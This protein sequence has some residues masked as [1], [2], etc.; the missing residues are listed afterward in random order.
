VPCP[1]SGAQQDAEKLNWTKIE[2]GVERSDRPFPT[3][4][5]REA[6][7]RRAARNRMQKK[8]NW[9]KI[10]SGVERSDRN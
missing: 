2:S 9:T 7:A 10:E 3:K 1:P 6:R 5:R 4:I 8:L